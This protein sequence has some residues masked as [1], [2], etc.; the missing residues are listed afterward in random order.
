MAFFW[1]TL[2]RAFQAYRLQRDQN[3]I[4]GHLL[5]QA[6]LKQ[7]DFDCGSMFPATSVF[8]P[9]CWKL[10]INACLTTLNIQ[11]L[12]MMSFEICMSGLKV[13]DQFVFQ[14]QLDASIWGGCRHHCRF[15]R[16]PKHYPHVWDIFFNQYPLHS[17]CNVYN[18]VSLIS[19]ISLI[20]L[21]SW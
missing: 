20:K 19:P 10:S 5:P 16:D 9:P 7:S 4:W 14:R 2:Q 15:L 3:L 21:S 11:S 12:F 13:F 8:N 6:S 18:C 1:N 17:V